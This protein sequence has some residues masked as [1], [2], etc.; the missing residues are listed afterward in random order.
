VANGWAF[1]TFEGSHWFSLASTT[2]LYALAGSVA[3]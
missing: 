2:L 1:S 3:G